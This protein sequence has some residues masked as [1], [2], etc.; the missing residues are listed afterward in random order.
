MTIYAICMFVFI[1]VCILMVETQPERMD[2]ARE[3]LEMKKQFWLEFQKNPVNW[4]AKT[5]ELI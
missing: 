5:N 3:K 1:A 2:T 4:N